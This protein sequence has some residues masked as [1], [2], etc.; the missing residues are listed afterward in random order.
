MS[1]SED[2]AVR[3][4]S[5]AL[6][7]FDTVSQRRGEAELEVRVRG[8][9]RVA[10]RNLS[11]FYCFL[12]LPDGTYPLVVTATGADEGRFLPLSLDLVV[13][14]VQPGE[15]RDPVLEIPLLPAPGY[16]F[17]SRC[18][19]VRGCVLRS[20][21]GPP[22]PGAVVRLEGDPTPHETTATGGFAFSVEPPE[23]S[24]D[25]TLRA[26]KSGTTV[27]ATVSV[28]P[29]KTSVVAPLLLDVP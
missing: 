14:V 7:P 9:K 10:V 18:T 8:T 24:V 23:A 20:A 4:L 6:W 12:D 21:D 11:G 27:L 15:D 22:V 26:T 29:E 25:R 19:V 16:P 2:V 28:R 3:R 13:P 1:P 5:A 17:P